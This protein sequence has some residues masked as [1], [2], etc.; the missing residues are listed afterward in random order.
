MGSQWEFSSSG[1]CSPGAVRGI[2]G[3]W[4][5]SDLCAAAL[6]VLRPPV[7]AYPH[8]ALLVGERPDSRG[9]SHPRTSRPPRAI[10]KRPC[11]QRPPA[12]KRSVGPRWTSRRGRVPAALVA[13]AARAPISGG[14]Q[15][16]PNGRSA[17]GPD[18]AL[19]AGD[20]ARG[21]ARRSGSARRLVLSRL[22]APG[23]G[24]VR[25][26]SPPGN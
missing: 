17:P 10:G 21:D 2:R 1:C 26:G 24:C 18:S 7:R 6:R 22:T 12:P 14:V 11:G 19:C 4:P 25:C 16:R 15:A 5:G 23:R 20:R 13:W 9:A 3:R 8:R